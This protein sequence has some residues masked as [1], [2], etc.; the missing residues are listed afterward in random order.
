[1]IDENR[2]YEG[3]DKEEKLDDTIAAYIH[4]VVDMAEI[5]DGLV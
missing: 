4:L 3:L 2:L 1:M 5:G